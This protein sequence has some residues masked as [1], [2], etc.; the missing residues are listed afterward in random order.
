M[1]TLESIKKRAIS[2]LEVKQY[3]VENS[4]FFK[5]N[6]NL[7]SDLEIPHDSG[8]AVSLVERQ[9]SILRD[10]KKQLKKQ[11]QDLVQIAKENDSLNRQ[12][13]KLSMALYRAESVEAIIDISRDR[14]KKDYEV[15][16]SNFLFFTGADQ[17]IVV[18]PSQLPSGLFDSFIDSRDP[19][20]KDIEKII[21][22]C[23]PICGRFQLELTKTLFGNDDTQVK[24]AAL[25]PL[26]NGASVEGACFGLLCIGSHDEHWFHAAKGTDFLKKLS[27]LISC[28]LSARL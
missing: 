13:H 11:L 12:L 7:L 1:T 27:E 24:S 5:S 17:S 10:Q 22:E 3:L 8:N 28:S 15:D 20:F 25:L 21:S 18:D 4:D 23:E 9:V 2:E 16:E 19:E 26:V 6:T 14:L